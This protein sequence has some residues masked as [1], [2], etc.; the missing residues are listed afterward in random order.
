MHAWSIALIFAFT[1]NAI[2]AAIGNDVESAKTGSKLVA[3][4]ENC[5]WDDGNCWCD[6]FGI[7][8]GIYDD[9]NC[10]GIPKD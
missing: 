8:P 6:D 2:A 9:E 4:F 7:G 10:D 5:W 1:G 3:R